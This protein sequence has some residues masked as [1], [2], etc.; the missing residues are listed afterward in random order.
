MFRKNSWIKERCSIFYFNHV[1][2]EINIALTKALRKI[3][4]SVS[5]LFSTFGFA[6]ETEFADD[7]SVNT[8][9]YSIEEN[10]A[11][12]DQVNSGITS[13]VGGIRMSTLTDGSQSA[14]AR[15]RVNDRSTY[16]SVTGR[17]DTDN[18]ALNGAFARIQTFGFVSNNIPPSDREDPDSI[19]GN[20]QASLFYD[21][22]GDGLSNLFLCLGRIAEDLSFENYQIFENNTDHCMNFMELSVSPE[23]SLTLGFS[24]DEGN[25]LTL[26]INGTSQVINLPGQFYP[27]NVFGTVIE[28]TTFGGDGGNSS[29]IISSVSTSTGT[30]D[31]SSS[32]PVLNRYTFN[33]PGQAGFPIIENERVKA[34]F[35]SRVDAGNSVELGLVDVG[36]YFESTVEISSESSFD[37]QDQSVQAFFDVVMANN[38]QDNGVDGQTGDIR[39]S[40]SIEMRNDGRRRIEYCLSESLDPQGND[41]EGLLN[42]GERSCVELPVLAELDQSYRLAINFDRENSSVTFRIDEFSHTEILPALFAANSPR[43]SVGIGGNNGARF[44]GFID[45]IRNSNSALTTTEID[46]PVDFPPVASLEPPVVDSTLDVPYDFE[47]TPINFVDDFSVDTSVLG[48]EQFGEAESSITYTDSAVELQVHSNRDPEDGG[49]VTAFDIYSVSDTVI[50][51][52]ALSSDSR[53]APGDRHEVS[54]DIEATIFNDTIDGGLENNEGDIQTRIRLQLEGS[55]RRRVQAEYRRRTADGNNDRLS[56]FPDGED[57]YEFGGF[58]PELDTFYT[59]TLQLD[60]ANNQFI[61]G[62]DEETIAVPIQGGIFSNNANR[63][64]IRAFHRGTSG[65]AEVRLQSIEIDDQ[66]FDFESSAPVLAPYRPRFEDEVEGVD[67]TILDGRLRMEA[68]GRINARDSQIRIRGRSVFVGADIELSSDSAVAENE[69]VFVGVSGLLY[70]EIDNGEDDSEGSVFSALRST[71]DG[72]GSRYVEACA[73]RSNNEDFS[74]ADELI[75]GD[76][77]NCPRFEFE[78]ALNTAYPA[79]ISLDEEASTLTYSFADEIIVYD[80]STDIVTNVAG[81]NGVRARP[82]ESSL[83]V[84]FADNLAFSE[85]PVPLVESDLNFGN[86]VGNSSENDSDSSNGSE[87]DSGENL[88]LSSSGGG[89]TLGGGGNPALILLALFALIR[90]CRQRFGLK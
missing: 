75:G 88:S 11:N 10:N 68:D 32:E 43:A 7:F 15:L 29:F 47:R 40:I 51:V 16:I 1:E 77:D 80:I 64:Q 42:E 78:P 19:A 76:P 55:G 35:T 25:N 20:I 86:V 52:G 46:S 22:N 73:F 2:N 4:I 54:L 60:R 49:G 28:Q 36:T 34:D 48:I 9:R 83:V 45:D 56:V 58:V 67:T 18:I 62:I 30:D 17:F 21:F 84:A 53:I 90:I 85:D 14:A 69:S 5:V 59:F 89:C 61:Y 24:I 27:T 39:G 33:V 12:S 6:Q 37:E 87:P 23:E 50:V 82:D 63:V 31:F 70:S 13:E 81:F 8:I 74:T 26:E 44:V 72:N 65:R 66:L 41:L 3:L 57:R 79:S 38:S 71:M